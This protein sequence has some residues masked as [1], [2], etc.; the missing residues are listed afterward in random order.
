MPTPTWST[1]ATP[2]TGKLFVVFQSLQGALQLRPG[3]VVTEVKR[4][5]HLFIETT[6]GR[7][8]LAIAD[9]RVTLERGVKLRE[10]V[11]GDGRLTDTRQQWQ[12][13]S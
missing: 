4:V 3:E 9:S 5:D 10:R 6:D 7:D 13:Y 2:S 11:C 1:G 8:D 12:A